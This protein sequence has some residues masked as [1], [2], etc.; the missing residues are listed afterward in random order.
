MV[1]SDNYWLRSEV[2]PEY[3]RS[4]KSIHAEYNLL[5]IIRE[6][7]F[8]LEYVVRANHDDWDRYKSANWYGL[9]RWIEQNPNHPERQEVIDHLRSIQD[10]YIRYGREYLGW[11]VY[12][13]NNLSFK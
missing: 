3:V 8:D 7:G 6:E 4:E 5:K 2:P 12:I 9:A 13:L 1:K 11:A 10:E